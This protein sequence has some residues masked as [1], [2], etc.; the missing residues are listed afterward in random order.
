[1]QHLLLRLHMTSH[2]RQTSQKFPGPNKLIPKNQPGKKLK[3]STTAHHFLLL[4]LCVPLLHHQHHPT[5]STMKFLS[6]LVHFLSSC[7]FPFSID[8]QTL[9]KNHCKQ[10]QPFWWCVGMTHWEHS[11]S[12][13]ESQVKNW[14]LK[15]GKKTLVKNWDQTTRRAISLWPNNIEVYSSNS[16]HSLCKRHRLMTDTERHG[17]ERV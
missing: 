5:H 14:G 6:F 10:Q 12:Q 2:D 7:F 3:S 16:L 9:W 13:P 11:E 1:M 17:W 4:P 15:E 8:A